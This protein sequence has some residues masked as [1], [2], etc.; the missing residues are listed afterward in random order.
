M[1]LNNN[2]NSYGPRRYEEIINKEFNKGYLRQ[3]STDIEDYYDLRSEVT[4]IVDLV[5]EDGGVKPTCL[6]A[7]AIRIATEHRNRPVKQDELSKQL[8]V[9]EVSIRN[10][11][12]RI[13]QK[14][15]LKNFIV[16]HS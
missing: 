8:R 10:N 15:L 3:Y 6:V 13:E 16:S 12:R 4:R 1:K 7:G 2:K 11:K 5:R 9:T 14:I